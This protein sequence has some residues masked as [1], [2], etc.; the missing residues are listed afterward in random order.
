MTDR[1]AGFI[2]TL[3]E[4]TREDDAEATIAA[5][6]QIKG[7]LSVEPV[8]S[9]HILHMAEQ[10]ARHELREKLFAAIYPS[11]HNAR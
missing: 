2:V 4:D 1:L 3:A 5:V 7:V 10:R 11:R 9:D 6:R 8:V